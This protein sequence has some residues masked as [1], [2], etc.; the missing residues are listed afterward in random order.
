[1]SNTLATTT[2]RLITA[3]EFYA[4]PDPEDGSQQELVLGTVITMAGPGLEHGE[5]QLQIGMLIKLFLRGNPI[6]RVFIESGMITERDPD[7]VRGPDLS[8]YSVARLPLD[9]RVVAYHNQP[10]DLAIEIRSP[11]N[12]RRELIEKVAEYLE[13]G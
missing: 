2:P 6:G 3:E 4:L 1:M 5:V 7:T 11:S 8:F 9:L 13:A 12:R 10:P